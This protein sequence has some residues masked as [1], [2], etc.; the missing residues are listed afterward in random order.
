MMKLL[1]YLLLFIVVSGVIFI[2]GC[3]EKTT[4][5][6]GSSAQLH[7]SIDSLE[8]KIMSIS[9]I[10]SKRG[11]IV[12][13]AI[14][15]ASGPADTY[16]SPPQWTEALDCGG[17]TRVPNTYMKECVRM[18]GDPE[19]TTWKAST[20]VIEAYLPDTEHTIPTGVSVDL[21][22]DD[23]AHA[24]VIRDGVTCTTNDFTIVS[25]NF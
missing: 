8:C 21:M 10:N 12:V 22:Y 15:K 1:N 13:R 17:W 24:S 23:K 6:Q 4:S 18:S 25:P 20:S 2:C 3:T 14:G 9:Q 5:E 11:N 16:L 7:V 19:T